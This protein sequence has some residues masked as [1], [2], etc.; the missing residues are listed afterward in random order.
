MRSRLADQPCSVPKKRPVLIDPS[1]GTHDSGR[2]SLSDRL[3]W[4]VTSSYLR[5]LESSARSRN[6]MGNRRIHPG[7]EPRSM[8]GT[9]MLSCSCAV[10]TGAALTAIISDSSRCRAIARSCYRALTWRLGYSSWAIS[11]MQERWQSKCSRSK[12][13]RAIRS[14]WAR[15]MTLPNDADAPFWRCCTYR[16]LAD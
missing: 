3:P 11:R 12:H 4:R 7:S 8:P 9:H 13:R 15:L 16:S 14:S 1:I 2:R 6:G 10:G 5:N